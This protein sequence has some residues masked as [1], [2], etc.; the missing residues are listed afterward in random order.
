MKTP[1]PVEHLKGRFKFE[2]PSSSDQYNAAGE[3][4]PMTRLLNFKQIG[5]LIGQPTSYQAA[6]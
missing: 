2:F 1:H 3:F 6:Y 4:D 5:L